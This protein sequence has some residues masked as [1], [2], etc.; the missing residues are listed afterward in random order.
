VIGQHGTAACS[1]DV[2]D[3]TAYTRTVV[4]LVVGSLMSGHDGSNGWP[5]R[6]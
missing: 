5:P 6:W 2:F 3:L 1:G 4:L